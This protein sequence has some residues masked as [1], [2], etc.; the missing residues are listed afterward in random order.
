MFFC[1]IQ[2]DGSPEILMLGQ[3]ISQ[4][5]AVRAGQQFMSDYLRPEQKANDIAA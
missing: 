3:F 4:S 1:I 5:E 2:R